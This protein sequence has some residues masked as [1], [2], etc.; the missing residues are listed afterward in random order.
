VAAC[1]HGAISLSEGSIVTEAA[2]CVV[3]GDCTLVCHTQAR[4]MVGRQMTVAD[5][6][7]EIKKDIIFYDQSGGGVTFSGGEPLMQPDFLHALLTRCRQEEIHT[8]VDTSGL[9]AWKTLQKISRQVDV[10]LYDLKVMDDDRHRQVTGVS[11]ELILSNL[12]ALAAQGSRVA[13]R[14]PLIPGV[15]DDDENLD[16]LGAFVASLAHVPPV[17]LLPYHQA[18][19]DKYA[20]LG[21]AYALSETRPPSEERVAQAV[22]RLQHFGL[23]V[24]LGG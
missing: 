24:K 22:D 16:R 23:Q 11:N 6:M 1:A 18:G 19:V 3:C 17:S 9:T 5:V 15:N 13:V 20:R 12:R 7:A 4:E 8:A 10:F 14:L 2:R 21:K